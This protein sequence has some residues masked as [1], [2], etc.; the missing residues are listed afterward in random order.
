MDDDVKISYIFIIFYII[1]I[2]DI[3]GENVLLNGEGD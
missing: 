3:D 2:C 1:N